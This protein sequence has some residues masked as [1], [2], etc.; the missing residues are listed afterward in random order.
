MKQKTIIVKSGKAN[1][2]K[3]MTLS[4]FGEHLVKAGA[5]TTQTL[6]K[7]DYHAYFDYRGKKVGIQTYGDTK[8]LVQDGLNAMQSNSCDIIAIASKGYGATV[9]AIE[10]F[11]KS[12]NFRVIWAKPY[13]VWDGSITEN[14]IKNY[15]A[16]HLKLMIDDVITGVL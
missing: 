9:K 10:A 2:G 11:A 4:R 16:S 1:I 3:S 15:S 13:C 8:K 5:T 7:K 14:D 12:N 6:P